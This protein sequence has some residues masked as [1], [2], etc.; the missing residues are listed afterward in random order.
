VLVAAFAIA[1]VAALANW[2][3]R[4]R[5]SPVVELVTKPLVTIM[6]IVAAATINANP[7]SAKP[8]VVAGLIC[9]L[10]GDVALLPQVD[11]FIVGLGAFL[12]GHVLF[13]VAAW[14]IGAQ[15]PWIV[16]PAVALAA[17]LA[18]AGRRIIGSSGSLAPAVGT[19]F[20]VITAMALLLTITL[21]PFAIV[22][23]SAFVVSDAILGWNK[24]V[25]EHRLGPV[26]VMVTYHV[27]LAG[28]V[29]MLR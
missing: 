27:A 10:V 24:F 1:A 21:R 15:W 28:L 13:G 25:K 20:A 22:G 11:T 8:W 9:C 4:M 5:P 6:M 19:Y 12:V 18:V 2:W 3:V 23:A 16:V 14:R 26:A 7:A 29:M 17:I